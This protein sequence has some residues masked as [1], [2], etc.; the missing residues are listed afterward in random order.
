MVFTWTVDL[1]KG[2]RRLERG[3]PE[4]EPPVPKTCADRMNAEIRF[5]TD[6]L[7]VEMVKCSRGLDDTG[8]TEGTPHFFSWLNSKEVSIHNLAPALIFVMASWHGMK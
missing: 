2:C 8:V 5:H 3:C 6:I 7:N 1:M 4:A